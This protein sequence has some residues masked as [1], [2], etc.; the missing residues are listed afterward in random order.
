M[1][2]PKS[3]L[4]VGKTTLRESGVIPGRVESSHHVLLSRDDI[5]K[6]DDL[7]REVVA[8]PEWGGDVLVQALSGTQRDEFEASMAVMRGKT[9]V[10][11]TENI[12][13]KLVARSLVDEDGGQLFTQHDVHALGL[14]SAAAL[15]RVFA[16]ASRLS[17][18]S[19]ED[20]DDLAGNS[21]A[22]QSGASTSSSPETSEA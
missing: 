12:R 11:D 16:V 20:I 2:P 21:P 18:L 6:A 5:L 22:A 10:P 9:V 19:D 1:T 3:D 13:A 4:P 8:C 17:G 7:P 15:D 14:K